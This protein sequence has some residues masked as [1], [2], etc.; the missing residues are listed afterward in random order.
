MKTKAEVPIR[1][2]KNLLIIILYPFIKT[3]ITAK[4]Q[5]K[6]PTH[7]H[8]CCKYLVFLSPKKEEKA[9]PERKEQAGHFT[10]G[11]EVLSL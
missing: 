8:K 1:P 4:H 10:R 11:P 3:S 2:A 7:W 6:I 9:S 5:L